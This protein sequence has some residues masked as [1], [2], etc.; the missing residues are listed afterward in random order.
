MKILV[1]DDELVSR[2]KM[3][4]IMHDLGEC[5]AVENGKQAVAA[6]AEALAQGRPFDLVTL[7]VVMPEMDGTAVLYAIRELEKRKGLTRKQG[8]RVLMVTSHSDKDTVITSI[9]A[10]CDEYV[11][12]PFEKTTVLEKLRKIGIN[13]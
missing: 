11:V 12:K 8:A 13:P 6:F 9:Q 5:K 4:R 1:V 7:D 3:H 2:N 10:G